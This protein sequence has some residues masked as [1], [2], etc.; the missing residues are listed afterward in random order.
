MKKRN[1]SFLKMGG[2]V[3][4]LLVALSVLAAMAAASV[5]PIPPRITDKAAAATVPAELPATPCTNDGAGRCTC[6]WV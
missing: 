5:A 6:E 1:R 4:V 3:L 2:I